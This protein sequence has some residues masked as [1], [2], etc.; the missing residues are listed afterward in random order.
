[1]NAATFIEM[2]TATGL[3][4]AHA[5]TATVSKERDTSTHTNIKLTLL[6]SLAAYSHV[7]INNQ[8]YTN[9]HKSVR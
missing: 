9:T 4:Q 3:G 8:C 7:N 2:Y 1:M 5:L 6:R